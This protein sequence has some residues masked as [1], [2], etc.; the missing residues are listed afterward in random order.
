[1]ASGHIGK[2]IEISKDMKA[3]FS[4]LF[5]K[6]RQR[7]N[8]LVEKIKNNDWLSK[9]VP[10]PISENATARTSSLRGRSIVHKN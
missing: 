8:L 7:S 3:S 10:F 4:M 5:P 6:M 1:M 9:S 2:S